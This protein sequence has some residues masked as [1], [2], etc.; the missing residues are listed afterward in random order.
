MRGERREREE[1]GERRE[2]VNE[3]DL[4]GEVLERCEGLLEEENL[5]IN[6]LQTEKK[7]VRRK[8]ERRATK[9]DKQ[10]ERQT[11]AS[12]GSKNWKK[13]DSSLAK[14]FMSSSFSA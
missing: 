12:K 8:N 11:Q 6:D 10:K 9:K 3:L 1:R 5:P 14:S 2:P 13:V 4:A 7:N